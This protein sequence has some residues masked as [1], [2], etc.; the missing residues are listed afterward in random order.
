[1][2]FDRAATVRVRRSAV[3][4]PHRRFDAKA[5]LDVSFAAHT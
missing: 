2:G 4:P 3:A 5:R 1:M